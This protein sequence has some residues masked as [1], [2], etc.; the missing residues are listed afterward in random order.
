[1][2]NHAYY[3]AFKD[4]ARRR[5]RDALN[6]RLIQSGDLQR[7]TGLTLCS[8][9]GE[10]CGNA[11]DAADAR[12]SLVD[13]RTGEQTNWTNVT[14]KTLPRP[15]HFDL[16][17]WQRIEGNQ[18]L[19]ALALGVPSKGHNHLTLKWIETFPGENGLGGLSVIPILACAEEYANLLSCK[20]V[21]IWE[22]LESK[23]FERFGYSR[24]R[25]PHVAHGGFYLGK[26]LRDDSE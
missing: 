21:L 26:E 6:K 16:A 9:L 14:Y 4:E 5:T 2:V 11:L 3:Y 13:P 17:V 7:W 18:E 19:V 25:H 23:T 8:I 22:P 12:T 10:E 15:D 24:Y 1:M 20:R